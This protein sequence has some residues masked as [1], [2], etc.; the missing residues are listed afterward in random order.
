MRGLGSGRHHLAALAQADVLQFGQGADCD[1]LDRDKNFAEQIER[2]RAREKERDAGEGPCRVACDHDHHQ[3]LRQGLPRAEPAD[4]RG[5]GD[6]KHAGFA[7][8]RLWQVEQRGQHPG[9]GAQ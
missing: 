5:G 6:Q 3:R 8:Q 9:G 4:Q 2:Y 1:R 7:Q